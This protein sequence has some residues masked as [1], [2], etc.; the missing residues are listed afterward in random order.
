MGSLRAWWSQP[1]DYA[2]TVGYTLTHPMLRVTRVLIGFYCWMYGVACTLALF[3]PFAANIGAAQW[4]LA[5]IAATTIGVG[6]LWIRGPFPSLTWSLAFVVYSEVGVATV[7]LL[8]DGPTAI[9]PCA[10]LL[11]VTGNY[12][13]AFHSA[14]VFVGHQLWAVATCAVLYVRAVSEPGAYFA[15]YTGYLIVLILVLVSSPV[16]TQSFL[17]FLRQDAAVAHFDPLTG[18][19]NRRGLDAAVAVL[20]APEQIGVSVIV[21]DLDNFKSVNDNYGHSY[22]DDVLRRTAQT[23][24]AVFPAPAVTARTGGEEFVAVV[25]GSLHAAAAAADRL[26]ASIPACNSAGLTTTSIGIHFRPIPV[27]DLSTSL[28]RLLDR[29]DAAMYEA[30]RR[31]GNSVVIDG[32]ADDMGRCHH[33]PADSS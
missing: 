8:L 1:S 18:L 25:T 10:A 15:Q 26:R 17:M 24:V 12:V 28:D 19:R 3:T 31:G 6:Y 16:L 20:N 27:R 7:L 5:F 30:K 23:I 21:V 22:G 33:G 32:P 2:W 29:A 13:A 11:G 14:K 4:V 9:L